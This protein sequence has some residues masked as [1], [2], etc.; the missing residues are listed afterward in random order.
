[1]IFTHGIGRNFFSIDFNYM[2]GKYY[3]KKKY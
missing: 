3:D 2:K 1:M